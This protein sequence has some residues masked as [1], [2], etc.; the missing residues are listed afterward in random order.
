MKINNFSIPATLVTEH[1]M[2]MKLKKIELG[3]KIEQCDA[4]LKAEQQRMIQMVND[5]YDAKANQQNGKQH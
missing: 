3:K 4:A 1:L 5:Y 2:D